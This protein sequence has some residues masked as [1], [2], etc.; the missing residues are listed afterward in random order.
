MPT[1][2]PAPGN[3][4]WQGT[5]LGKVNPLAR[6]RFAKHT[7]QPLQN[8]AELRAWMQSLKPEIPF[9]CLLWIEMHFLFSD[10]KGEADVDNLEK[11]I[12]DGLQSAGI[13]TNDRNIKG[14]GFIVGT[15]DQVHTNII[16]REA[17]F[18]DPSTVSS[19]GD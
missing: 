13:I 18:Y 19:S 1:S 9:R 11:A 3:F 14:G 7:Y 8:Q 17:I 15:C 6:P 10:K 4:L 16:L 2:V 12:F 5:F